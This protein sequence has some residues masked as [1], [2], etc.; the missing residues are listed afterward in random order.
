[1]V[2]YGYQLSAISYQLFRNISRN[3]YATLEKPLILAIDIG[4]SS[5]RAAIYDGNANPIPRTSVKLERSFSV[6]ADG[7]SELNSLEAFDQVVSAIDAVLEKSTKIKSEIAYVT[8]CSFWHSLVGVDSGGNPT[9]S[10][11]GWADTRSHDYT[12]ILRKK[13]NEK[14]VHNRTG[15][16]FHSSYWPAKLLWLQTEFPSAYANAAGLFSFSDFLALKLFDKPVTSISMASGTGLF[17]IRKCEWDPEL[18]KA[19]KIKPSLLPPIADGVSATYRLNKIFAKRWP[20]LAGAKWFPTIADGAADNIGAGCVTASKA[21]LMIGT[22]GAMRVAYTGEPPEAIP[23]GLWCYRVDRERVIIGGALSD[24][25]GLYRWLKANLKL[26]KDAEAQIANRAPSGLA[27]LPFLAGERSTGYNED[28]RGA[29][30]GLTSATDSADILQSALESVA[31]RFAEIFDQLSTVVDIKQIVASGGALRE[32][33]VWAQ[34]IADVL[35]RDLVMN[36]ASESSLRGAALLALESIG[37]IDKITLSSS[38]KKKVFT[39]NRD[40]F[41]LYRMARE[42]HSEFYKLVNR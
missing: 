3:Q 12:E 18:V 36:G 17:D 7:G 37:K 22:S 24:G 13:L 21:A 32:S 42:R 20:R 9:P 33:A 19:L 10:I 29:M 30:F 39:A 34:I 5:V 40:R 25:G 41:D 23:E 1:M 16:R 28:A 15:A 31:F 27:F 11:L 4:T 2:K 35:G 38:A 6:T 26:P 8:S 14:E